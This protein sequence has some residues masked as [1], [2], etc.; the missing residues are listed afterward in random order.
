LHDTPGEMAQATDVKAWF[1][2]ECEAIPGKTMP[3]FVEVERNYPDTYKKFTS[4]GP[5][6][7]TIGNGGKGIA[8]NTED[9]ITLLNA[10]N[11]TVREEGVSKG[12]PK[13]ETDIDAIIALNLNKIRHCFTWDCLT[14]IIKPSLN[15][16]C[17]RHFSWCVM[18]NR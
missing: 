6:M 8:W 3:S 10:L 12:L 11:A 4:L 17:L 5:L 15:I 18:Q 1:N 13:I 14:F 9:E 16:S 7:S 2:D